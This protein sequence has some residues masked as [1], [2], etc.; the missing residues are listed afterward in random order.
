MFRN[1]FSMITPDPSQ[2]VYTQNGAVSFTST[3]NEC[4]DFLFKT[5]RGISNDFLLP[6]LENSYKKDPLMTRRLIFHIRDITQGKG[7]KKIFYECICIYISI[8]Y[9][10]IAE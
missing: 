9:I 6:L 7:E 1:L 2:S 10:Y 8:V 4:N 5:I 3:N